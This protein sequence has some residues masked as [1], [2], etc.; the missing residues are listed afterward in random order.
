M[1]TSQLGSAVEETLNSAY[2]GRKASKERRHLDA[3]EF[4]QGTEET[5][6][7]GS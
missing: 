6:L 1:C 4:P 2:G 3:M 5:R 7:V